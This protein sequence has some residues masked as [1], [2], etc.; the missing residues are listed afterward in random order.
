ML[1]VDDS[2]RGMI[3]NRTPSTEIRQYAM[4]NQGMHTLLQDGRRR[5]LSGDT[6]VKEVL[7]VCQREDFE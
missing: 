3:V 1:T 6:T 5:I 7:R 4:R 2:V